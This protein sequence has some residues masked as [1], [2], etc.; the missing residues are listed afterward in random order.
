ML[1]GRFAEQAVYIDRVREI[2]LSRTFSKPKACVTTY[3]CQQNVSDSQHIKGMLIAM[4]YELT[5]E[6]SEADFIL[7]N[8]CAVREH[9]E[10][11]VWGNV[12][13]IKKYKE[14]KRGLILA[15]CGCMVLTLIF[16]SV[17]R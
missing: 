3:G 4:G 8:T 5:D 6:K 12:G 11:R 9:A 14:K 2:L 16:F 15:V 1:S 10:D 7:F 13:S 17:R